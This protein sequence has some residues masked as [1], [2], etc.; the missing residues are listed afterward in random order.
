MF[1]TLLRSSLR[2]NSFVASNVKHNA[3]PIGLY[4]RQ[5]INPKTQHFPSRS[6]Q[7]TRNT[8]PNIYSIPLRHGGHSHSHVPFTTPGSFL[9][10]LVALTN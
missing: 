4:L 5:V 8:L 2:T 6:I 1:G 9:H 10:F 7:Y 3:P